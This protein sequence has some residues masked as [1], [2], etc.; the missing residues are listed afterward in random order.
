MTLHQG[1]DPFHAETADEDDHQAIRTQ[2]AVGIGSE[3]RP[4]KGLE[5]RQVIQEIPAIGMAGKGRAAK[6]S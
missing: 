6:Q 5:R 3:I 1:Q 4:A 2:G